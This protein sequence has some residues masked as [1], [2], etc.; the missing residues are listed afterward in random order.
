M[1]SVRIRRFAPGDTEAV[2][3]LILGIQ[4]D[5][6]GLSLT[7]ADQP[8]L[9]DIA[10]F[11]QSGTGDF[12]LAERDGRVVGTIGLRDIGANRT[13]L[14]KMFVAAGARGHVHGTA[15]M[16][17][18]RLVRDARDR[19]VREIL[20]GT[21]ERFLAAHRFY[22]RNGFVSVAPGA[23]P[24]TFPRMAVDTRFYARTLG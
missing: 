1:S 15:Q 20:L 14:R 2:V 18:D 9:S 21:T 16:L 22:E 23:L 5:E 4:R 3:A 12:L 10:G 19:G 11:Y 6:F 8:D 7:V 13:A 24:D 17:L